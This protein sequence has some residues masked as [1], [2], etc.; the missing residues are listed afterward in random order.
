MPCVITTPSTSAR[1]S[2]SRIRPHSANIFSGVRWQDGKFSHRADG[3]TPLLPLRTGRTQLQELFD[4]VPAQ[5]LDREKPALLQPI[6]AVDRAIAVENKWQ[7]QRYGTECVFASKDGPIAIGD[8]LSSVLRDVANDAA[9]NAS[10]PP[11]PIT[12]EIVTKTA[13]GRAIHGHV[14]AGHVRH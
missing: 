5:W 13:G 4:V 2:V 14:R 8:M 9:A 1:A 10:L 12:A 7:A 6:S 3:E 11:G